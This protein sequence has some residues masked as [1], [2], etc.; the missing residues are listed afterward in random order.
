MV[1]QEEHREPYPRPGAEQSWASAHTPVCTVL[2]LPLTLQCLRWLAEREGLGLDKNA[3]S[4]GLCHERSEA[5]EENGRPP[6]LSRRFSY[7]RPTA[8]AVGLSRPWSGR[9]S[10]L[11]ASCDVHCRFIEKTAGP[12]WRR[13]GVAVRV[14]IRLSGGLMIRGPSDA[15]PG[16]ARAI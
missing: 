16:S 6:L 2:Q 15:A 3:L 13:I 12:H 11:L 1:E 4:N 8:P 10:R 14:C 9:G 5:D 7:L